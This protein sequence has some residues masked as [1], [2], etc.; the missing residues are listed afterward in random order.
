MSTTDPSTIR[1]IKPQQLH[2]IIEGGKEVEVIDVRTPGEYR[3]AHIP[4]ANCF[5]LDSLDPRAIIAARSLPNEPLYVVCRSGGRSEKA[6]AAFAAAGYADQVVNVVGGTQAWEK[7]G[8]PVVKGRYVLPLDRQVRI[9]TG[10]LVLL[11]AVLG[12]LV[13]PWFYALSA[14]CGAGMIFA[15][16]TDICPLSKTIALMPWNQGQSNPAACPR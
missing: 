11:G 10:F 13:N 14:Y 8:Y 2:E 7:A 9:A 6:C 5:P 4:V 1:S 15:G 3:S 16:I 12:Y